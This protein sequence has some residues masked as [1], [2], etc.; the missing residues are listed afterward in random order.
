MRALGVI[1]VRLESQRLP[2]KPLADIEGKTLVQRVW[3]QA[4]QASAFDEI[5]IATDSS[6]IETHCKTFGAAVVRTSPNH[7]TGSDR[8]GEA[9]HLVSSSSGSFD[10]VANI[11]GDMPFISPILIDK[12]ANLLAES[13]KDVGMTTVASPILSEEEFKRA[14]AVKV[15]LGLNDRALYFSRAPIPHMRAPEEA[16]ITPE[17][18]WGFKHMGLYVFR[19]ETLSLMSSLSE[20][21]VEKREKLE[22]LRLLSAGVHIRVLRAPLSIVE[23]SIE[24]DTQEDL[25][26]ARSYVKSK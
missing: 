16:S 20:A 7:L 15:A 12:V 26:R 24:V 14:S 21:F 22:Q 17:T 3:E 18:P 13:S 8:V 11:Q 10:I 5:V 9:L 25:E 2:R 4:I 6:E 19:P 1:P 23:P